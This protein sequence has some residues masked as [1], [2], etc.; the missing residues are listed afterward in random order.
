MSLDVAKQLL[1]EWIH[2]LVQRLHGLGSGEALHPEP[3]RNR[4]L[5]EQQR[6]ASEK[7][8]HL[9][10]FGWALAGWCFEDLHFPR[11]TLSI[12]IL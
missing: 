11:G 8:H 6:K 5:V 10:M 2:I 9:Y 12:D 1:E 3:A 4:H 7:L